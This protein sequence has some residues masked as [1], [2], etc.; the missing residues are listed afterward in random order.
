MLV[1]HTK[2]QSFTCNYFELYVR[3]DSQNEYLRQNLKIE[4]SRNYNTS[5]VSPEVLDCCERNAGFQ[6]LTLNQCSSA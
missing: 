6:I 2:F 4:L 1:L 3:T 5:F